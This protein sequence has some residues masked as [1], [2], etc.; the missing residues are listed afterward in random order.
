MVLDCKRNKARDK[1]LDAVQIA[2]VG[3]IKMDEINKDMYT[4]GRESNRT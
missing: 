1:M 3:G 4:V 2:L